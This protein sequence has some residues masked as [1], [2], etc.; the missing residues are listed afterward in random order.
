MGRISLAPLGGLNLLNRRYFT[1]SNF[2]R[3]NINKEDELDL[4]KGSVDTSKAIKKFSDVVTN[5][6]DIK[7]FIKNKSGIYMWKNIINH[8]EYVGS[9]SKLNKRFREYLNP[10]HLKM[11]Y[12]MNINKALLKYGYKNFDFYILE[13][14]DIIKLHER[15]KFYID[16]IIKGYN[17]LKTPGSPSR[18]SGWNHST[19]AINLISE[20]ASKSAKKPNHIAKLL[21]ISVT[22]FDV[23]NSEVTYYDSIR[24]AWRSH[25][26]DDNKLNISRNLLSKGR[27]NDINNLY[28]DRYY[29]ELGIPKVINNTQKQS[30][31][32]TLIVTDSVT[33]ITQI[34][35]S[36][37]E[38]EQNL[39]LDRRSVMGYLHRDTNKLFL[40]RYKII[41]LNNENKFI[42]TLFAI[43][44][45]YS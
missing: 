37:G 9:S 25:R 35:Y 3:D 26:E 28:K 5:S 8:K 30:K 18:V 10:N 42:L 41:H 6:A 29:F 24:D 38:L 12:T 44:L 27:Y 23:L 45:F 43:I 17:I 4:N 21:S 14:C 16:Q 34:Y 20:T 15:E 31:S 33:N 22:V 19:E 1:T 39:K 13:W 36:T 40:N 2:N 32:S 7:A 11:N